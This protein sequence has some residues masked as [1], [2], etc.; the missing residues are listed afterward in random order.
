MEG[1]DS[2]EKQ[3]SHATWTWARRGAL[4]AEGSSIRVDGGAGGAWGRDLQGGRH[5]RQK[6]RALTLLGSKCL[7]EGSVTSPT[8]SGWIQAEH[9][10]HR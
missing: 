5:W 3:H 7:R 8:I 1:A 2:L 9:R 6:S 10:S 4:A